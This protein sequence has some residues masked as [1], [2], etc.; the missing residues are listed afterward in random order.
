M[1]F[2]LCRGTIRNQTEP[3]AVS[4]NAKRS[5]GR[6]FEKSFQVPRQHNCLQDSGEKK[7]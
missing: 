6:Y 7:D 5:Q 4:R 2:G 1:A 3:L